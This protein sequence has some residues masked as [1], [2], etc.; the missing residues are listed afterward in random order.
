MI[1]IK[2]TTNS[3]LLFSL[4][5]NKF[6]LNRPA[7]KLRVIIRPLDSHPVC[8]HGPALL[9]ER[10]T[11]SKHQQFYACSAYRDQKE[12]PLY[13]S[14]DDNDERTHNQDLLVENVKKST[15]LAAEKSHLMQKVSRLQTK[16]DST[17]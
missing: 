14:V 5:F 3:V 16:Q 1:F 6:C 13:V 8:K 10:R 12:C 4:P 11:D 2:K 17:I 7:D 9:F 15:A